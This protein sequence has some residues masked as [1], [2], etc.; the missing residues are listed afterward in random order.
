MPEPVKNP[1]RVDQGD[2]T[3]CAICRSTIT[4]PRRGRNRIYCSSNCRGAGALKRRL[5]HAWNQGF[6]AGREGGHVVT[7]RPPE[8]S[9]WATAY[10]KGAENATE[11]VLLKL[12]TLTVEIDMYSRDPSRERLKTVKQALAQVRAAARTRKPPTTD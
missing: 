7:V 8:K 2:Q 1:Y 5:A 10:A 4:Q 3:R 12:Q 11:A 9:R 6:K